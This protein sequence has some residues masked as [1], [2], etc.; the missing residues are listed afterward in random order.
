MGTDPDET[1]F[2][3]R[4]K[5]TRKKIEKEKELEANAEVPKMELVTERLLHEERKLKDREGR[6]KN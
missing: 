1:L 2:I 3:N 4:R 5:K 6:K